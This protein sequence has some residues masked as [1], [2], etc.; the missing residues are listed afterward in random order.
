MNDFP[1]YYDKLLTSNIYHDKLLTSNI[2]HDKFV[3]F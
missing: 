3:L 1:I 2:Y